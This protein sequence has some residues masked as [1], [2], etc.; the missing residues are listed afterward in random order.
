MGWM[1]W[2]AF[3]RD[4]TE[5]AVLGNAE[6]L[7]R[8]GLHEHG[9][10]YVCL[11]DHWHGPRS[12]GGRLRSHPDRFPHGIEWLA[13]QMHEGGLKLGIYTCAGPLTCG[14]ESGSEGFEEIDAQTFVEWGVDYVKDDYCHAPPERE[15]A[16]ERYARMGAA[17]AA[18]ERDVVFAVCEWGER[19]PWEWAPSVGAQLWRTGHDIRDSW[20]GSGGIISAA[21]QCEPLGEYAG[22]GRWNDPDMLVVGLRGR[23]RDE[24][25]GTAGS[26]D[27]EYRTQ[28]TLWAMLAAPLFV[29]CDLRSVDPTTLALLSAPGV[30]AIDQDADGLTGRR[31]EC[32]GPLEVWQR[33]LKGGDAALA[34]INRTDEPIWVEFEW[35]SHHGAP[36]DIVDAW[37]D[38][39]VQAFSRIGLAPHASV[40]YRG[41][42]EALT[43]QRL[44]L[45]EADSG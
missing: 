1:S 5:E 31:V 27:D 14:G 40:L 32:I 28:M 26:T 16:I 36:P 44:R 10:E 7:L 4:L 17:L 39:P 22:P 29:S 12:A 3:G 45:L 41:P 19:K 35:T 15:A 37:T 43:D 23:S 24:A 20:D 30:L 6:A 13:A 2:N 11:D 34:L 25:A 42:D 33:S 18:A 21:E 8:A 38:H 9:Y